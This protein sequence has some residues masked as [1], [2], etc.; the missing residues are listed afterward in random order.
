M[1]ARRRQAL[2]LCGDLGDREGEQ[3][4]LQ[5][6]ASVHLAHRDPRAALA[7][8]DRAADLAALR[9]DAEA[10][11][12]CH[13]AMARARTALGDTWLAAVHV[14]EAAAIRAAA[15]LRPPPSPASPADMSP[16]QA[17]GGPGGPPAPPCVPVLPAALASL[18]ARGGGCNGSGP[19]AYGRAGAVGA[20]RSPSEMS[21]GSCHEDVLRAGAEADGS[22][23]A[24]HLSAPRGSPR[25]GAREAR[26]GLAASGAP[27]ALQGH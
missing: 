4:C 2:G 12:L 20:A 9:S 11:A 19:R 10:R 21:D 16:S 18:A 22:G 23:A 3:L 14:Q 24:P 27:G 6:L 26:P 8:L 7:A 1:R 15:G 17:A 25:R 13:D 5:L